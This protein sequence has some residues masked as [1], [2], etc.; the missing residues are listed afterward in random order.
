MPLGEHLEELRR[1]LIWALA[2]VV[3]LF[4]VAFLFGR[5][6]LDLLLVPVREA[7]RSHGLPPVAM[8]TGPLEVFATVVRIALAVTIVLGSP[9]LLWQA[10]LFIAPGLYAHERRFVYI[11]AP[12]SAILTA[13]A[14]LFLYFVLLPIILSF[15]IGF[16]AQLG[17]ESVAARPAPD[18]SLPTV[19]VLEHD[20]A[21]APPGAFWLNPSRRELRIQL[22]AGGE[23]P[24]I[25]VVP[26]SSG[27]GLLQQFRVTEYVG[28]LLGLAVAFSL[29]FQMPVVVLL[30]GWVG[31][32][33]RSELVRY[34]RHAVLGCAIAGALL[35][36]ADPLSMVLLAVPLYLLYELGILMLRVL[37][38]ERVAG[39]RRGQPRA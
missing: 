14:G 27:T 11:L 24:P 15:F 16:G 19:P 21:D 20:P 28:L 36:P 8:A 33:D 2:G 6:L 39:R 12:L 34:R 5:P 9:W 4:V 31:V 17:A 3:P 13:A 29:G 30:L 18:L 22:P 26:L 38:A 23:G 37:P 1:R 7:L 25:A 35:T 32:L 10:W